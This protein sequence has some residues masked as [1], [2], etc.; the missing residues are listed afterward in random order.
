MLLS[1]VTYLERD[2]VRLSYYTSLPFYF[3]FL[4]IFIMPESPR[5][6]LMRGRLEEALRILERMA[7]VNGKQFPEVVHSKLEAQIQR[8]KLR[9]QKKK[10]ANVG[11]LDLCR[12]PNMRLKTILI[13]L[14]WFANETVY[15][16]LSYYGP[17]LG[18]NQYVSFF[19]SAVVEIP[20]YLCCWYFMDTWGRRWPLSLSMILG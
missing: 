20:S 13:T 6:L 9:N 2:W 5:W 17:S 15:L 16:G 3:Y 19:L 14:S 7:R 18:T 4:Y 1:L 10:V 12:T 8:D 11:L